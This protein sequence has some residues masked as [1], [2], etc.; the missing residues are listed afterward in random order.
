MGKTPNG[1][2]FFFVCFAFW[3]CFFIYFNENPNQFKSSG[4]RPISTL[5]ALII[6]SIVYKIP[7]IKCKCR[8]WSD[9]AFCDIWSGSTLFAKCPSGQIQQTINHIFRIRKKTGRGVPQEFWI[10]PP[11]HIIYRLTKHIYS[12]NLHV[13]R[14]PIHII[15]EF[16][17][18]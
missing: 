8:P 3:F 11:I 14:Y 15:E 18:H 2:Q 7:C 13:K 1:L 16:Y 5:S 10:H 6:I 12:Y 4:N 9:A 17:K